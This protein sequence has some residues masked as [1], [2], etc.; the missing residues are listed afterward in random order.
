MTEVTLSSDN[1]ST[2]FVGIATQVAD[3][4]EK[5]LALSDQPGAYSVRGKPCVACQVHT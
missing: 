5:Y 2:P 4:V 1:S 3:N